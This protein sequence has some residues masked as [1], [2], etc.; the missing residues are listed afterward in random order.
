VTVSKAWYTIPKSNPV[1]RALIEATFPD[2]K[3]RRVHLGCAQNVTVY[4]LNWAGGSRNVYRW[5]EISEALERGTAA[6]T[7]SPGPGGILRDEEGKT[8]PVPVG[9][10][11]VEHVMF[12]G[13]DAGVYIRVNPADLIPL[14]PARA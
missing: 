12:Q 6:A 13:K 3:G 10:A 9:F 5:V 4:N 2:W 7:A 11:C 8:Y 14:L 1:A